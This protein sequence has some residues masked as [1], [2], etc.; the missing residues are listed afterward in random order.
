MYK[1]LNAQ[2]FKYPQGSQQWLAERIGRFTSTLQ[3]KIKIY[4]T[5]G[6]VIQFT[7]GDSFQENDHTRRGHECEFLIRDLVNREYLSDFQPVTLIDETRNYLA[8]LDGIDLLWG[9]I[10]EIKCPENRESATYQEAL[11]GRIPEA[12]FT[13]MQFAMG[14]AGEKKCLY[15]V[16]YADLDDNGDWV[17][18]P[19]NLIVKFVDFCPETWESIH[20]WT[21]RFHN[22]INGEYDELPPEHAYLSFDYINLKEQQA[23]IKERL[24]EIE[25]AIKDHGEHMGNGICVS[26]VKGRRTTG[27][28][29]IA[30]ACNPSPDLVEQHTKYG[31]DYLKINILE[32]E[33]NND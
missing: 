27:W 6:A 3:Y 15:A 33:K 4:P 21:Q 8:S 22:H 7:E 11:I 17:L 28:Q 9:A 24:D 5:K 32:K 2:V 13:Q 29:A 26:T 25:S 1:N 31:D 14:V 30:R 23:E 18:D 19:D 12:H 10:C 20:K 16:C